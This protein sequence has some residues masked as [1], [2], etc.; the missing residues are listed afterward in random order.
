MKSIDKYDISEA[1]GLADVGCERVLSIAEIHTIFLG[2]AY[3]PE[4]LTVSDLE[5]AAG[6]LKRLTLPQVLSL[7][8]KVR[9]CVCKRE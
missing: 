6:G 4:S 9:V 5:R 3:Q 1:F 8:G 7:F 2:L